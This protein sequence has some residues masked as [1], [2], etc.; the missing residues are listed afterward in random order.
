MTCG[1]LCYKSSCFN[2]SGALAPHR[3]PLIPVRIFSVLQILLG[4]TSFLF[5]MALFIFSLDSRH[6]LTCEEIYCG[7]AFVC[8][9]AFGL[10]TVKHINMTSLTPFMILNIFGCIFA[11]ILLA[12]ATV[13]ILMLDRL[14]ENI[15]SMKQQDLV[16][17]PSLNCTK[18]VL[19]SVRSDQRTPNIFGAV[20]ERPG[21]AEIKHN[22][23]ECEIMKLENI[24][25][26]L[27]L[28]QHALYFFLFREAN[29]VVTGARDILA[30]PRQIY[31]LEIGKKMSD[32][33]TGSGWLVLI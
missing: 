25:S 27:L 23:E 5:F 28:P 33:T 29:E 6:S 15:I 1:S 16:L 30:V 17:L 21:P 4:V 13:R 9:G 2:I 3:Y 12:L 14:Q 24:R 7:L 19:E 32:L 20:R 11:G 22:I 18:D 8:I 10:Y 26:N 31:L